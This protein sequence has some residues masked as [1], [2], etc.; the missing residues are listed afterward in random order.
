MKNILLLFIFISA[1][2]FSS[3]KKDKV[4]AIIPDIADIVFSIKDLRGPQD[5]LITDVSDLNTTIILNSDFTWTTDLGGAISHGTYIYTPSG[6]HERDLILAGSFYGD[7]KFTISKW[8]DFSSNKILSD[9]LKSVLQSVN[10]CGYSILDP[11]YLSFSD[12]NSH[13]LLRSNK[14]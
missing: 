2:T 4:A 12:K 6:N 14:K 11:S 13:S 5:A 1:F 7:F 8:T 3:C 10:N 9:K